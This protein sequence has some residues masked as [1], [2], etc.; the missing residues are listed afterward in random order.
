MLHKIIGSSK[1]PV[2]NQD[3]IQETWIYTILS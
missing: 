1:G 3:K 2:E